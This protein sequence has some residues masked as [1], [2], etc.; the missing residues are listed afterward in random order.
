MTNETLNK[1]IYSAKTMSNPISPTPIALTKTDDRCL[2]VRWSNETTHRISFRNLRR[3]CR[4]AHCLEQ[5]KETSS[6]QTDG[7]PKLSNALPVLSA[8]EARP[9]DIESMQPAGNYGY[10]VRFSDG[11]SSGIY[12][13]ELL[14]AIGES[15]K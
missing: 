9:L 10:K 15:C 4:C 8:A 3:G 1:Q 5:E 14:Y 12:S 7:S 6:S 11:H 2:E 13:F